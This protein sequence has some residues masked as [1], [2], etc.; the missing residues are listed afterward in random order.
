MA[1]ARRTSQDFVDAAAGIVARSGWSSLTPQSLAE[2]LGAHST[3]VYRHFPTW[4]DLVVCVFDAQ[5]PL[6]LEQAL[7]ELASDPSPRDQILGFMMA[8]RSATQADPFFADCCLAILRSD[9]PVLAPNFDAVSAKV[10]GL[11]SKMGVPDDQ[12]PVM[13]QAIE[14]LTMGSIIVDYI[15][16]PHHVSARRQRRRMSGIEAFEAF[17]RSDEAT[18]A[19]SIAAFEVSARL[20]LDECERLA[21]GD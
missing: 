20:L 2:E 6:L 17:T 19:V 5:I 10:A 11:I 8:V 7:Q 12:V 16:H 13:Y 3:A 1:R 21:A 9:A 14:M 15:G 4:N 18:H